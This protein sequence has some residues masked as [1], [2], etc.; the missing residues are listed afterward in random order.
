MATKRAVTTDVH[1]PIADYMS[2]VQ[3]RLLLARKG[4]VQRVQQRARRTPRDQNIFTKVFVD[5]THTH[6]FNIYA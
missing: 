5:I 2:P 3:Q 6:T 4:G 1:P